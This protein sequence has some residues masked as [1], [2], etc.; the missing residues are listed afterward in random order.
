M[1]SHIHPRFVVCS[2]AITLSAAN[3]MKYT[4]ENV[5]CASQIVKVFDIYDVWTSSLGKTGHTTRTFTQNQKPDEEDQDN[6]SERTGLHRVLRSSKRRHEQRD[7]G[8]SPQPHGVEA[9]VKVSA[10]KTLNG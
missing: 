7:P 6:T 1:K 9:N 5:D 8:G 2:I 3:T 4:T 10:N